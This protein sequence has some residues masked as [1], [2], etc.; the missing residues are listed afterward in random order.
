[1]PTVLRKDKIAKHFTDAVQRYRAGRLAEAETLC[2]QLLALAPDHG[3]GLHLLGTVALEMQRPADA[4]GPLK[5]AVAARPDQPVVHNLL[6]AA[7]LQLERH[8]DAGKC[9]QKALALKPDFAEARCALGVA[10]AGL[11]RQDEAISTF[12]AALAAN[13]NLPHAHFNL[14]GIYAQRG[15]AEDAV[16][17]YRQALRL[18]PG[19]AVSHHQL[20]VILMREERSEEALP[21]F[22]EA[23]RLQPE[24][25]EARHN[26]GVALAQANRWDEAVTAFEETLRLQPHAVEAHY[27][28]ATTMLLLGRMAE[29]WKEFEWR[30]Q[31]EGM[32]PYRRKFREPQWQGE[33]LTGRTL[34]VHDEQGFGDTLHFCRYI[35]LLAARGAKIVFE[36][37]PELLKTMRLSFA[38]EQ[39]EIIPRVPSFPGTEGLPEADYQVPLLSLPY[40]FGTRLDTVPAAT[41]YLRADPAESRRWQDRLAHLPRPRIGLIWAGRPTHA[42][43]PDRSI[44]LAQLAPLAG[45]PGV[46]FVSLQKGDAA[47][48]IATA[49]AGLAVHDFT[50]ELADF[51]D[52]AAF[53]GAIDLVITVDTAMAHLSGALGKNVW[54]MNR[55]MPD[56]RWMLR[57][58]DSPWYPTMRMFRQSKAREWDSVIA[59]LA[60][61]LR[62]YVA[63]YPGCVEQ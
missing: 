28:V 8:E 26:V 45:I 13:P 5:R 42:Q 47:A 14:A 58:E 21:H 34:I 24:F 55:Y 35:P 10:L 23:V 37:H 49:P 60:D 41:P 2:R 4:I 11:G 32:L 51:A 20:G 12:R 56:W 9:F 52:T 3:Q 62:I 46:S 7:Y 22:L 25:I 29:G 27:N 17:H 57:R 40:L 36:C 30:W 39:L 6:G 15:A 1:M 48:Q 16:R 33:D 54:M 43:D 19:N 59:R 53:L 63:D 44:R 31:L 61:A 50:A 38:H 18:E